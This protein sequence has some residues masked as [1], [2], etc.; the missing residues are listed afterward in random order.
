MRIL[1]ITA[2]VASL[3]GCLASE[4]LVEA[5]AQTAA[6][7]V[8]KTVIA[9]KLPGVNADVAVDCVVEN[10]STAQLVDI[11]KAAVTGVDAS[12]ISTVTS[13]ATQP[14]TLSCIAQ[15]DLSGLLG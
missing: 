7:S 11:A 3:S 13:I 10:A 12:T 5:T 1:G 8:I 2:L 15:S 6:K 4:N 14:E 9:S